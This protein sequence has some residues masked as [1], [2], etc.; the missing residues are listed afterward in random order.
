MPF[1]MTPR[2]Q[3]PLKLRVIKNLEMTKIILGDNACWCQNM[4]SG[5]GPRGQHLSCL[6][7]ALHIAIYQTG[8]KNYR[9]GLSE[10]QKQEHNRDFAHRPEFEILAHCVPNEITSES[11]RANMGHVIAFNDRRTTTHAD[12][13][14]VLDLAI[15]RAHRMESVDKIVGGTWSTPTYMVAVTAATFV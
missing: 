5:T 12:V 15:E 13:I 7:D 9:Y 1:D 11:F 3:D 2:P 8:F 6:A 4:W 14:N 10:D